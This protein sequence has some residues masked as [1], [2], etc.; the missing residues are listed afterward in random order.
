M[1][2]TIRVPIEQE[3]IKGDVFE[4]NGFFWSY[5]RIYLYQGKKLVVVRRLESSEVQGPK[6]LP[7]RFLVNEQL[8]IFKASKR[9]PVDQ[10]IYDGYFSIKGH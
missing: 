10:K 6:L 1:E 8:D 7:N 2:K 9:Q 4:D 3:V 5:V